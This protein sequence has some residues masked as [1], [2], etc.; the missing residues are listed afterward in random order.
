MGHHRSASEEAQQLRQATR[1]AHEAAQALHDAI[2]EAREL[3]PRLVADFERVHA[4]EIKQVSNFI[5]R[6]S[7]RVAAELNTQID[8]AKEMIFNRIMAGELVLDLASNVV[9][10]RLGDWRFDEHVPPPYPQQPPRKDTP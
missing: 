2:R 1:E 4:T 5:T 6:E 9:E 3:A 7:N 10:L 8:V